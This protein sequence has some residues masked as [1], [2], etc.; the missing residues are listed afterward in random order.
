[1]SHNLDQPPNNDSQSAPGAPTIINSPVIKGYIAYAANGPVIG[2]S[3]VTN[4]GLGSDGSSSSSGT[5]G[6]A[7]SPVQVS[8]EY[9]YHE[10]QWR[11]LRHV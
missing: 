6:V 1:M 4:I 10:N 2:Y 5:P 9:Y 7:T 11:C 3:E 8:G